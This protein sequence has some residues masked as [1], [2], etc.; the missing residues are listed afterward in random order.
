MKPSRLKKYQHTWYVLAKVVDAPLCH[1]IDCSL[2]MVCTLSEMENGLRFYPDHTDSV[3]EEKEADFWREEA[4][5]FLGMTI[6]KLD[7]NSP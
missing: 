7:I 1:E 3:L 5:K 4:G 2:G 6:D